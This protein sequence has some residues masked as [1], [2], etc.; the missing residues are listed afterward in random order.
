MKLFLD[1]MDHYKSIIPAGKING[2]D[3]V[4]KFAEV[5]HDKGLLEEESIWEMMKDFHE[6]LVG[7]H[8]TEPY[9]LYQVSKMY[10]TNDKDI[11]IDEPMFSLDMAKHIYNKHMRILPKEVTPCDVYVALNAQYHDNITL[12]K[13]WFPQATEDEIADKIIE[14]TI[15]DWFMDEDAGANKVW[16]YFKVIG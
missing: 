11:K 3:M 6:E 8:F 1:L 12:Y 16:N 10:H 9:A 5:L 2:W 4:H 7:E 13:K 14:S 15:H